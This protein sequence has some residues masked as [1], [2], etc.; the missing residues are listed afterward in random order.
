MNKRLYH[1]GIIG[2]LALALAACSRT[3]SVL[4][5]AAED[6]IRFGLPGMSVDVEAK[7]ALVGDALPDSSSFGVLGYCLSQIAPDKSELN[8][9]S[10]T[11]NWDDKKELCRPHLFY[12]VPVTY[13]NGECTYGDLVPWYAPADYQY[14]FFAY[15]PY[16][17]G[18]FTME[19]DETTLGSPSVKFTMPFDAGNDTLAVLD[20]AKVPD[21]MVA[22]AEDV[23]RGTNGM[24][25]LNFRHILTGL[26]FQINNYNEDPQNP[27]TGKTL[28]IHS[29]KLRGRFYKS[30]EM[31][32]DNGWGSP[33]NELYSG[34]YTL[35]PDNSDI[36]IE[37]HSEGK[38]TDK[39][40]LLV[41]GQNHEGS[42]TGYL[43]PYV[44]LEIK[45]TFGDSDEKTQWFTRPNNFLP[46][47][48]TVYTSQLNFIGDAFVL[49]IIVDNNYQWEDG[50]D[51]EIVFQ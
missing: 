16:G 38:L 30:F 15:Y 49:N 48:G 10:A 7:S 11:K 21:A 24:V 29:L 9:S 33:A 34:T 3:E 42:E 19:S 17:G 46:A 12:N 4:P 35:I 28:T 41:S 43:G 22:M 18:Y 40:L 20:D 5:S 25:E 39:T 47:A 50:G 8:E 45:Y 31:K 51:S 37:P 26:N 27:E 6:Y 36:Q 13:S 44:K 32:Y 1:I 2:T 23:T 14:T